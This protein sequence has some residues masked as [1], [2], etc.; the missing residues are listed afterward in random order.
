MKLFRAMR[1]AADG[2]PEVG[3]TARTLGVRPHPHG[4]ADVAATFP[5]DLV[6]PGGGGASVAPNDPINLP[7]LR[8]P[9]SLGGT[10]KDPVWWIESDDLGPDLAF[11]QQS[12]IH[13]LIEPARTMALAELD[14]ALADTRKRWVV[15]CR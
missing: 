5:T 7:P 10:G 4:N 11:R 12:S 1:E 15:H 2:L 9:R 13:G 6:H 14:R 8:R 3:P